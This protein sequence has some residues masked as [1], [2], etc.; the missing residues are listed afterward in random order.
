MLKPLFLTLISTLAALALA[1]A[2]SQPLGLAE[3]GT[4]SLIAVTAFIFAGAFKQRTFWKVLSVVAPS[5]IYLS[6]T[7]DLSAIAPASLA[8]A[9][10][11]AL[12]H[13]PTLWTGVPHYPSSRPMYDAVASVLPATGAHSFVDLGSGYGTMLFHLAQRF[14]NYSFHGYEISLWPF[15]FSWFRALL[16][17]N[18]NIHLKSFWDINLGA[19]EFVYSFLAPGPMPRLWSKA[20][21]E[22][23][24]GAT[25]MTNTF[26]VPA[27]ANNQ[28]AVNDSRGCI[29]YLHVIE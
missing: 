29:L 16:F 17:R 25:F 4:L 11:L 5:A 19:Y 1:G 13:L 15:L 23:R 28:I 10:I 9:I 3:G 18:V 20:C 6:V 8:L 2:V 21:A 26:R 24:P 22:M 7:N 12:I 27:D 14:P